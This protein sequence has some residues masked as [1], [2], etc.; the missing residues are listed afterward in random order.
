MAE[1]GGAR[2]NSETQTWEDGTPHPAP[3]TGPMPPRPAFAPGSA[4]HGPPPDGPT[5]HTS[6]P[7]AGPGPG[8]GPAPGTGPIS[9][10][11]SARG[12]NPYHDPTPPPPPNP[13]PEGRRRTA[14]VAGAVVAVIA[15]GFGGGYLLWGHFDETPPAAG[16]PSTTQTQPATSTTPSSPTPPTTEISPSPP[17]SSP[18]PDGYHRV[19]DA[20]GF[21]IAVPDGWK[22][23][24]RK[25]GVFYTAP[26]DRG[27]V[28]IFEITEP[29]STPRESLETASEGLSGNPGY[30]RISLEPLNDDTLSPDAAQLVYAYDSDRLGERVKVVDCAFTTADGRQFAV[31]VLGLEADWPQQERTQRIALR[32]FAPTS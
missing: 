18:L 11:I 22:R 12:P 1:S 21:T 9:E 28:Q 10:P 8:P 30:E 15:V 24:V 17:T 19:H 4:P 23:S 31:L 6:A 5:A 14:L 25:T 27:L 32:A 7:Y 2:W 16:A 29:D 13:I 26:D 20:K 3:Y